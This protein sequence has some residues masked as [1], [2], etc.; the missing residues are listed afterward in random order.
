[1]EE[2]RAEISRLECE[3]DKSSN[4][5]KLAGEYGL[6]VLHEKQELQLKFE[7]LEIIYNKTNV[8]LNETKN[9]N[10]KYLNK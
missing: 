5:K 3:L 6:A 10:F 7:E 4:D 9:V 2:L 8:D 1:M